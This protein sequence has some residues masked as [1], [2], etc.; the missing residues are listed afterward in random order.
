MAEDRG[1]GPG[2]RE[3]TSL[4]GDEKESS[5]VDAC[6]FLRARCPMNYVGDAQR[7]HNK[8]ETT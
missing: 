2:R 1:P 8:C 6:N 7:N 4:F 3:A 5:T